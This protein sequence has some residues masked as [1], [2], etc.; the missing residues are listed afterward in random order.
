MRGRFYEEAE[1]PALVYHSNAQRNIRIQHWSTARQALPNHTTR[2]VPAQASAQHLDNPTICATHA[3]DNALDPT[4]QLP[5][6]RL[7]SPRSNAR[8]APSVETDH[9]ETLPSKG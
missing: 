1:A 6:F 8:Q 7:E 2:P 9:I 5:D 3:E 4:A